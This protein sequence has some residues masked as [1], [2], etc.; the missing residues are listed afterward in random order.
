[1]TTE[2]LTIVLAERIM[3]WRPGP[4]RFLIDRRHWMPRWRFQPMK[5][6]ADAF[7]LLQTAD[8]VEYSLSADGN[9]L[10]RARVRTRGACGEARGSTLPQVICVAVARAHGI[11]A[12][13]E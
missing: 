12:E 3:R 9:G 13:A 4:G 1:M 2:Q 10:C 5:N 6:I 11:D 8:V 7:Q